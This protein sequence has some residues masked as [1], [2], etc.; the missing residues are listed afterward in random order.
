MPQLATAGIVYLMNAGLSMAAAQVIVY[1]S[2][3]VATGYASVKIAEQ[4]MREMEAD[5]RRKARNRAQEIQNMQFGTVAPRRF[6]YGE[7]VVNGHLIFQETAG[8][9]NKDL[10]RVVYLGEGPINAAT[11]IYFNEVEQTLSGDLDGAGA[12]ISSGSYSGYGTFRVGVNGNS[13]SSSSVV[14]LTANTSW[15]SNHKMT[16]NSWLAYKLVHNNEVWTQGIPQVRVK[17]QGRK[18]Y[19]PRLDGGGVGGGSGSHRYDDDTTWAFSNNSALCILDFLLNGMSVDPSDIDM[20]AMRAAADICD[21]NVNIQLANGSNSTQARYTTNGVSFL[22][23]EVIATLEQLL[24]PC[25][26]TLVEEAGVLRL[27]VPKDSSSVVVGLTE[28]DIVSELNININS[29]V[30][31]RINKVSGTFTDKDSDFQQT[32]FSPISSASLIASDGREHLQQIDL[33]MITDEA[34]AQRLASIVLKENSLTNT[35]ELVLKPKFSYLKVMDVVTVTFEPEKLANVGTDSIVTTA[36]KWRIASYQLT[37]QGA[38]KVSLE[39]YADSSYTW[40]TA[41]HDYLTRTALAD[42][43]IDTITAPT[44][45]TP[46]KENF[47]DEA[48]NQVLAMRVPVTHGG[49]PNFTFTEIKLLKHRYNSSN[50]LQQTST[51]ESV[52]LTETESSVLFSGMSSTPPIGSSSGDYIRH[53]I[54]ARTHTENGKVSSEAVISQAAILSGGYINKDTTAP[55]VP[56][57]VSADGTLNAVVISWT[58]PSDIDLGSSS[59]YRNTSNNSGTASFIGKSSGTVFTDSGLNNSQSFYYWVSSVDRVGNESAKVATGQ[60]TTDAAPPAGATGPTGPTGAAG[61]TGPTGAAGA[62]GQS[63]L[64]VTLNGSDIIVNNIDP[65]NNT[66]AVQSACNTAFLAANPMLS[67]MSDIPDDAVVWARFVNSADTEYAAGRAP[68]QFSA[69]KWVYADQDWTDNSGSFE[70]PAIFSPLV[71]AEEAV[72]NHQSALSITAQQLTIAQNINYLDGGGWK[73]GKTDYADTADGLW[74][75]NPAGAS[76]FALATGANAGSANEHGILFD[77]NQTKLINPTIMSGTGSLQTAVTVTSNISNVAISDSNGK[78]PSNTSLPVTG[79]SISA[80]GGGGGGKGAEYGADGS[81]GTST[82]Y[83]LTGRYLGASSATIISI[84]AAGGAGG[85]TA[86]AWY[87]SAGENSAFAAGGAAAGVSFGDGYDGS[88]GSGGGGAGGRQPATFTSSTVGGSGGSA[89]VHASDFVDLTGYTEVYLTITLGSGGAG[90]ASARFSKFGGDGGD[91]EAN[92]Q[93]QTSSLEQVYLSPYEPIGVGQTWS[94]FASG[95]G[96]S[97]SVHYRNTTDQPIMVNFGGA[98]G[99]AGTAHVWNSQSSTPSGTTG[100]IP[101]GGSGA[102]GFYAAFTSVIVPVGGWY[103]LEGTSNFIWAELR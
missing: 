54:S 48:G 37:P 43:F 79:I 29:E 88:K 41:D 33:T 39:E 15:T 45:G 8:T 52:S 38:V 60:V 34:R 93:I 23:D 99:S 16:G 20:A 75:G 5:A 71:I 26:G 22:N 46:A 94:N 82:S 101:V 73:I 72:V 78:L 90:G 42:S 35:I 2:M 69:R 86:T 17:V 91:G 31:G 70:N 80:V 74:I 68:T 25:H 27:L 49:H 85:S 100:S 9:D 10:Y 87:G 28:D 57:N 18:I 3:V 64:I 63:G 76:E 21:E 83:V 36:T 30:A 66:S 58:N 61:A 4:K 11:E 14:N 95:S 47:L 96:R 62:T 84:T 77:I 40:N 44:L 6:V 56:T 65:R 51:F 92:Y 53:S 12:S 81:N 103:Y 55:S 50:V 32:D 89:G 7:M 97:N 1:G 102:S 59:I 98:N 19:D 67:A 24:V 13:G